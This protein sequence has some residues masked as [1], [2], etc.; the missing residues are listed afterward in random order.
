MDLQE[1]RRAY[2]AILKA[3]NEIF[4]LLPDLRKDHDDLTQ[5]FDQGEDDFQP[6]IR[7]KLKVVLPKLRENAARSGNAIVWHRGDPLEGSN[8]GMR[9][10]IEKALKLGI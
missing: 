8:R 3:Y 6:T 1:I 10:R 5:A 9:E 7:E 2:A 4:P